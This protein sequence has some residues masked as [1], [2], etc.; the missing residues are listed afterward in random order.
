MALIELTDVRKRYRVGDQEIRAL[1]GI[2]L[3]IEQGEYAAIIGPSGSGKSTLM[4]LLGCLD[5]PTTGKVVIDGV[6]VSRASDGRLAEMRNAKIGFVFQSFNL[7]GKF[8][9]LENVELPMIYSGVSKKERRARAIAAVERVGLMDRAKNT[10]LQLSGGQMQRVAIARALVND[11][12]IVF[13]DEPTG[14][15]DSNTGASILRLFR[16]LSEQG[17]TIVLVTHDNEIADNAPRRIE[18]RDGKIVNRAAGLQSGIRT[19]PPH[20]EPAA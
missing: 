11:P 4:H 12:K 10:P 19:A 7:L 14:N 13:A 2:D 6:D 20:T 1:D 5:I 16:E 15:L 3:T 9:V 18:I 17:R 8:T